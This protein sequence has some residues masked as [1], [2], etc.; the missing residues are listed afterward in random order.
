M[1][2]F[3]FQI[4]TG[5][6][7][8]QCQSVYDT[9]RAGQNFDL[10]TLYLFNNGS[11]AYFN[12]SILFDS[13][14]STG[15]DDRFVIV[16]SN[17][18]ASTD[19]SAG[20]LLFITANC[21]LTDAQSTPETYSAKK[22]EVWLVGSTADLIPE[23]LT[24]NGVKEVIAK[25]ITNGDII[26]ETAAGT[27]GFDATSSSNTDKLITAGAVQ[28]LIN[29]GLSE[30]AVF[31][32]GF[33]NKVDLITLD[34]QNTD[35]S[36]TP[37]VLTVGTGETDDSTGLEITTQ[38]TLGIND[39]IGDTGLVFQLQYG[40][41]Y[42]E[43]GS[44]DDKW[45]WLNLKNLIKKSSETASNFASKVDSGADKLANGNTY[46]PTASAADG[47]LSSDKLITEAQLANILANVLKD[48][49]RYDSQAYTAPSGT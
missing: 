12:D 1:P 26:D 13:S 2:R 9:I 4:L 32:A 16:S 34:D 42:D 17:A 7:K 5:S 23:N 19:F 20:Q 31:T 21:T 38:I 43:S 40:N 24:L 22:G 27:N 25:M 37:F 6:S 41:E 29:E 48:Y 36:N 47:N 49:V 44:D 35:T 39:N 15:D 28:T 14:S 45:V 30:A 33:Y 46:D 11:K 18:T 10:N 8:E 3:K